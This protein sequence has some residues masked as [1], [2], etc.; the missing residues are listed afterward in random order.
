MTEK[1]CC[2]INAEKRYVTYVLVL[3]DQGVETV[4]ITLT[5]IGNKAYIKTG[6]DRSSTTATIVAK[7]IKTTD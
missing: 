2:V 3:V 5:G 1:H 6:A 7:Y 4:R